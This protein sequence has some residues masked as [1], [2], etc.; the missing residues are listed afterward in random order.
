[1]LSLCTWKYFPLKCCINFNCGYSIS[2]IILVRNHTH[3]SMLKV[4]MMTFHR[5]IHLHIHSVPS[6]PETLW[7]TPQVGSPSFFIVGDIQYPVM[8]LQTHFRTD[9]LMWTWAKAIVAGASVNI[10]AYT[11]TLLKRIPSLWWH[12]I[13][14]L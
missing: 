3:F 11:T 9:Y 14:Q 8:N 4:K 10:M 6:N 7:R 5:G 1:M 2:S 12:S 13:N